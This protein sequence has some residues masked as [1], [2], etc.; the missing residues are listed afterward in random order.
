MFPQ[1]IR[2]FS[3]ISWPLLDVPNNQLPSTYQAHTVLNISFD[4]WSD[5]HSRLPWLLESPNELVATL[6]TARSV[7][8]STFAGIEG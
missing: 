8:H 6:F 2:V 4:A 1:N 3:C 5:R 7:N